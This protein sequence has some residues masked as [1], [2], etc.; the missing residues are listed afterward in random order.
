MVKMQ[1]LEDNIV[2]LQDELRTAMDENREFE[3]S[4]EELT[5]RLAEAREA[6]AMATAQ[7]TALT[8]IGLDTI[9][10]CVAF[11]EAVMAQVE[12]PI[13]RLRKKQ[14]PLMDLVLKSARDEED[15]QRLQAALHEA[16]TELRCFASKISTLREL[17]AKHEELKATHEADVKALK[18]DL[19]VRDSD[20]ES[21]NQTLMDFK[22]RYFEEMTALESTIASLR[23][24]VTYKNQTTAKLR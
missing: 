14:V 18:R 10:D 22:D 19:E 11:N 5:R 3:M 17:T 21:A 4:N 23:S 12:H 9:S 7:R 24:D 6:A 16:E 8:N 2:T 20:V 15:N 1:Q 13:S